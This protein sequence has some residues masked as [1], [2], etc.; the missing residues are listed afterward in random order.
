MLSIF[1]DGRHSSRHYTSGDDVNF[2]FSLPRVL[3]ASRSWGNNSKIKQTEMA[4]IG[5][6]FSIVRRGLVASVALVLCGRDS[7]RLNTVVLTTHQPFRFNEV[8][9]SF[10]C[11]T[12]RNVN[13][14]M[15]FLRSGHNVQAIDTENTQNCAFRSE[16]W[17]EYII[18]FTSSGMS[19]SQY[20]TSF[21]RRSVLLALLLVFAGTER[22]DH[23]CWPYY[24][25][26]D[27]RSTKKKNR[28]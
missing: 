16:R 10:Y 12:S 19:L 7:S 21:S 2:V 5:T 28:P 24:S 15:Y 18:A 23:T 11:L 25:R 17:Y 9:R 3:R 8:E 27:I 1:T 20:T 6:C 13:T 22:Y 26:V 14:E 4:V